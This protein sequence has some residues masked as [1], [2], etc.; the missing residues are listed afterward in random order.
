MTPKLPAD[1]PVILFD[2]LC[3][4]C[5][6]S[7]QFIIRHDKKDLFRFASLQGEVGQ[8]VLKA[9]HLPADDLNSFVLYQQGMVYTKSSGALRVAKQLNG[10]WPL[11][12][13]F[14]IIPP[15]IRNAIYS[16][17]ASNRYKWFGKKNECWLPTPALRKKF[18][19]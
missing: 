16:W 17:V 6:S 2:G 1:H 5:S 14:I 12:Y 19:D 15:F 9:H 7:V 11:L 8:Q 13:V 18:I 10:A 4:L 3:N